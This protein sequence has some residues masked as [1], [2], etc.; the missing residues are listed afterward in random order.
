MRYRQEHAYPPYRRLV[1]LIYLDAN[2]ERCQ[3]ETGRVANQIKARAQTLE[4]EGLELIGPAPAF[5]SKERDQ[6]RWHLLFRSEDPAP[7]LA[8]VTLTPG[9]RIDVD[10]IDT[11]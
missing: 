2:R 5:F 6:L 1:R 7:L 9:W 8:G 11:L 3:Q 4:M 10:P